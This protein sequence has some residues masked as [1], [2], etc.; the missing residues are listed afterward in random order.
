[1][2]SGTLCFSLFNRLK[3]RTVKGGGT[4]TAPQ[5]RVWLKT[6][7]SSGGRRRRVKSHILTRATSAEALLIAQLFIDQIDRGLG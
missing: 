2:H 3:K 4:A 7:G 6:G 1:M 5:Q